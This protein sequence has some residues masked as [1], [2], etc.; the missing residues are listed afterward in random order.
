MVGAGRFELPTPVPPEREL[1]YFWYFAA[2]RRPIVSL[3]TKH[4]DKRV[5]ETLTLSRLQ[6]GLQ[7]WARYT[8]RSDGVLQRARRGRT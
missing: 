3:E 8:S 6:I 2:P 1:L 5:A 7:L 4:S